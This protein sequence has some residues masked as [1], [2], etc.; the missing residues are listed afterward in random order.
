MTLCGA[1]SIFMP[2]ITILYRIEPDRIV[3][4]DVLFA[5][6]ERWTPNADD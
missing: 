2:N 4:F 5:E 6:P 1:K 3:V